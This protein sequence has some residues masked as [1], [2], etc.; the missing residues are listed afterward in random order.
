MN[1]YSNGEQFISIDISRKD[2]GSGASAYT[3]AYGVYSYYTYGT[4]RSTTYSGVNFHDLPYSGASASSTTNYFAYWYGF[5]GY[6][7][8]GTSSLPFVVNN[9]TMK[10]IMV[11]YYSYTFYM[12]YN[13]V[14]NMTNNTIDNLQCYTSGYS[15]YPFYVNYGSDYNF[16]GNTVKNCVIGQGGSAYFYV[17][18]LYYIYNTYRTNN[19]FEENVVQD[20]WSSYYMFVNYIMYYSSYK[21]NRNKVLNNKT[22]SNQGYFYGFYL[23]YLYNVEFTS[24]LVAGNQGYYGDMTIYTFIQL[25]LF[26]RMASKYSL[27][28]SSLLWNLYLWYDGS[29]G[30]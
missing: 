28:K 26:I 30:L 2:A 11:Y 24:N 7:N 29:R 9:V 13:Y 15:T 20:N 25:R 3:S 22:A 23:V 8:Y 6:Y 1:Q 17:F 19:I 18:Y 14:V 12:Y 10:N 5:Y 4:N 21:I 16:T 27:R